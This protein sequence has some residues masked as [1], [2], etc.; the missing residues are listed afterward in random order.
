MRQFEKDI[1]FLNRYFV[2][3]KTSTRN[4]EKLTK[5]LLEQLPDEIEFENAA[6]TI[7]DG[8][9]A[10]A[11]VNLGTIPAHLLPQ[12]I[13]TLDSDGNLG[14]QSVEEGKV[15][16]YPITILQDTREGVW[17]SGLPLKTD[18]I[19]LGQ[20]YVTAGQ[21]VDAKNAE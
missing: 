6:G 14:V 1:S 12:S 21:S 16:F 9:T 17:V 3:K 2:Y 19:V 13:M 5:T 10:E 15:V 4:A 18:L 8:L 7:K 11:T 20:E